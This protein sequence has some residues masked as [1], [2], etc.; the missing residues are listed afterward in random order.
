MVIALPNTHTRTRT[1]S[2]Y[3]GFPSSPTAFS[4]EPD[5]QLLAIGTKY[6]EFR[7]YGRPGVEFRSHTLEKVAI[8]EVFTFSSLHLFIT[9]SEDN[10]VILWEIDSEGQGELQIAKEFKLDSDG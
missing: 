10:N 1:Q 3:L 8:T 5:S 4:Y 6:G 9:V 2:G 7:I